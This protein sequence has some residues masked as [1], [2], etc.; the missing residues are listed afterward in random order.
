MHQK[1]PSEG[2]SKLR[3]SLVLTNENLGPRL[4]KALSCPS[5]REKE[6]SSCKQFG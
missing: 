3:S 1:C 4:A 5:V 6:S 2:S